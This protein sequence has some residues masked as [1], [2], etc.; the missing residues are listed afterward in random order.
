MKWIGTF[1]VAVAAVCLLG[2]CASQQKPEVPYW[3]V[4][5]TDFEGCWISDYIAEGDVTPRDT[6][7]CFRAMQRR[8][9]SPV[10]LTFKYPLGRPVKV[11]GSNIIVTPA[12]KPVWLQEI[13]HYMPPPDQCAA[14]RLCRYRK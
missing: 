13:E 9:F 4:V 1:L 11:L 8:I 12:C 5:L 10:V 3:H 2:G 6:G 7:F 14:L